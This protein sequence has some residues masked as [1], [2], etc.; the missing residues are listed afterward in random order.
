MIRH[1]EAQF[2]NIEI[3]LHD[4]QF[5]VTARDN[6]SG[7]NMDDCIPGKGINNITNRVKELNGQ[8]FWHTTE[9]ADNEGCC[10]D[11]Q[12]PITINKAT[13]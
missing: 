12:F 7:F 10:V 6:G 4:S 8:V 2:V 3:N 11:I 5:H 13:L 1:T 9:T